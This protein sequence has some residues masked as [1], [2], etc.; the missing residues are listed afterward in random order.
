MSSPRR[1]LLSLV[2]L[3]IV[4]WFAAGA[5]GAKP[6]KLAD[7]REIAQASFNHDGSRVVVHL[8]SGQIGLWEVSSGKPV[9]GDL[10]SAPADSYVLSSDGKRVAVGFQDGHA[11]V[12]DASTAKALSPVLDVRLT[13]SE[14]LVLF[15]PDG[16]TILIFREREAVVFNVSD[17]KRITT[18]PL[19]AGPNEE[20]PGSAAF[21]ANGAQCFIMDGAGQVTGYETKDWKPMGKAMLHPGGDS[22]YDFEFNVSEDGKW[23][24]TSDTPGENGPKG[25]LQVW[26]AVAGKPL[27]EPLSA[28]NGFHY[29]FVGANSIAIIPCR[30]ADASLHE[31]PS[32]NVV[33][34]FDSHEDLD[35]MSLDVSPDRKWILTWGEDGRLDLFDAASG[36]IKSRCNPRS[37]EVKKVM[38]AP[39]SSGCIVF[40]DNSAFPDQNHQDDYVIRM[41]LPELKIA[42]S[43]RS[44]EGVS[45]VSLSPDGKRVMVHQ[46]SADK[47]RLLF[48]D[49]AT[50]KPLK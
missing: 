12:F 38:M 29:H 35:G 33:S 20:T 26:D 24:A 32:M 30:G 15:S 23:L 49:A 14:K 37:V 7:L 44:L 17:G 48:Y 46:G 18:I 50:L 3:A 45:S 31:L 39:D 28:T 13:A 36:K 42:E 40:F 19:P 41:S 47:E 16:A 11:R 6:G 10:G 34:S 22:A 25:Q 8:S 27:G 5:L 21:A 43:L 2:T 1:F 4:S 9:A